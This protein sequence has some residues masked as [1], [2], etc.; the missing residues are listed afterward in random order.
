MSLIMT[1][2]V[3]S[4]VCPPIIVAFTYPFYWI[5]KK[6]PFNDIVNNLKVL[7]TFGEGLGN[8][9]RFLLAGV[10]IFFFGGLGFLGLFL[11]FFVIGNYIF[12]YIFN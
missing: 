9:I 2:F 8:F 10:Y 12:P 6:I 4:L 3:M 11:S 7:D 1:L 5:A